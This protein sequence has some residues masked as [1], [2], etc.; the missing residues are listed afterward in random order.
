MQNPVGVSESEEASVSRAALPEAVAEGQQPALS[1]GR[2]ATS[3]SASFPTRSSQCASVSSNTGKSGQ[4]SERSVAEPVGMVAAQ[5]DGG[6]QRGGQQQ[7]A[8]LAASNTA[9]LAELVD[10]QVCRQHSFL[11][12]LL[13]CV[14]CCFVFNKLALR[15]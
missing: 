9:L 13:F 7:V 6:G 3:A 1:K 10:L 8:R 12:V 15:T 2:L 5:Q 14:Y 4:A 11:G